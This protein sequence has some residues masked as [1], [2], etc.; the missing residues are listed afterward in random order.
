MYAFPN[1]IQA[2]TPRP[3][4]LVGKLRRDFERTAAYLAGLT[5]LDDETLARY[6][7]DEY[8]LAAHDSLRRLEAKCQSIQPA[9]EGEEYED[10][11][12]AAARGKSPAN[13]GKVRSNVQRAS[14]LA[15]ELNATLSRMRSEIQ[16]L[17]EQ[18]DLPEDI[19]G[20]NQMLTA[21]LGE[22]NTEWNEAV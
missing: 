16:D 5:S 17:P 2:K 7:L 1:Q 19:A 11:D 14:Q 13:W 9:V 15:G 8:L 20:M 10:L 6:R 22:L 12:C 4:Q 3:S 21:A 18:A